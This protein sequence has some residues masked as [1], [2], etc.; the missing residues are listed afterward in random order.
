VD[1]L[2]YSQ[3]IC[4]AGQVRLNRTSLEMKVARSAYI[5]VGLHIINLIK[6]VCVMAYNVILSVSEL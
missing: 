4:S 2:S 3:Y 6:S 1:D 5:A